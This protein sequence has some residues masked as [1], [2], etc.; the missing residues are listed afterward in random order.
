MA[1]PK[2]VVFKQHTFEPANEVYF[3]YSLEDANEI[4]FDKFWDDPKSEW[5]IAMII[6]DT[7]NWLSRLA[8]WIQEKT[9][10]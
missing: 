1:K 3:A 8:R 5:M 9:G 6:T 10:T 7:D 4:Q 2:Y